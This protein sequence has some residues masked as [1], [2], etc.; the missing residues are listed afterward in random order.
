[1]SATSS[2]PVKQ[3]KATKDPVR[4]SVNLTPSTSENEV[5]IEYMLDITPEMSKIDIESKD[6]EWINIVTPPESN[7]ILF[8]HLKKRTVAYRVMRD[9]V[10]CTSPLLRNRINWNRDRY[11]TSPNTIDGSCDG[12]G[13]ANGGSHLHL[14]D[15]D[16]DPDAVRNLL[17]I[18]H[19]KPDLALLNPGFDLVK[20]IAIVCEKYQFE[21][22]ILPWRHIWTEK[23]LQ[24]ILDPGYEDWLRIIKIF[25]IE[26]KTAKLKTAELV[27]V[28]GEQCSALMTD[29]KSG[30]VFMVRRGERVFT[31]LWPGKAVSEIIEQ[32]KSRIE[33]LASYLRNLSSILRNVRSPCGSDECANLACGSLTRSIVKQGLCGV[34]KSTREWDGSVEELQEKMSKITISTHCFRNPTSRDCKIAVLKNHFV[35]FV[36][37][38]GAPTKR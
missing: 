12:C 11:K 27:R 21:E 33:R 13:N 6:I 10:S 17:Q 36:K 31:G 8:I 2:S 14:Y 18:I 30:R 26:E 24:H 34:L 23:F 29:I 37:P 22:S 16:N 1:M 32:R 7:F 5:Q 15:D 20:R 19:C 4:S 3:V 35:A 9:T 28:L 25:G 38:P